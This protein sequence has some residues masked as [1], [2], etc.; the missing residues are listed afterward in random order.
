M[1]PEDWDCSCIFE[2]L[3]LST[4]SHPDEL[5]FYVYFIFIS[6]SFLYW[7][8]KIWPQYLW[9]NHCYQDA[10]DIHTEASHEFVHHLWKEM[11]STLSLNLNREE[12]ETRGQMREVWSPFL[13][14]SGLVA[15]SFPSHHGKSPGPELHSTEERQST[16][17]NVR[18][19]CCIEMKK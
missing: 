12:K 4:R 19:S 18:Q 9:D 5:K 1:S 11:G 14:W 8:F 16:W 15:S 7:S 6:Y 10:R 17:L 2:N 3:P 13:A